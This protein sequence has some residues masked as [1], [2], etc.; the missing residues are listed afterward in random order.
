MRRIFTTLKKYQR[1]PVKTNM[2][3]KKLSI[4]PETTGN[5]I[6]QKI[7]EHLRSTHLHGLDLNFDCRKKMLILK[8]SNL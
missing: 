6:K 8:I 7:L 5:R 1:W 4:K 2:M 3:Q